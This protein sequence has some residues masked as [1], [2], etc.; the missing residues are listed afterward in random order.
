MTMLEGMTWLTGRGR[1]LLRGGVVRLGTD[2]SPE[3]QND[4]VSG[5]YQDAR[6]A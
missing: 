2:S 5:D 6:I 1:I 4:N 3:A